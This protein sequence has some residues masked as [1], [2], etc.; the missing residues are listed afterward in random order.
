MRVNETQR[1]MSLGIMIVSHGIAMRMAALLTVALG[2]EFMAEETDVR[3][4]HFM[5]GTYSIRVY[6]KRGTKMFSRFEVQNLCATAHGMQRAL[7]V[8][9]HPVTANVVFDEGPRPATPEERANPKIID[10]SRRR[11]IARVS[12]TNVQAVSQLVK[13]FAQM[14]K[15]MKQVAGGKMP[16]L[17]QLAG[18]R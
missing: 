6:R 15:L 1:N 13:Q 5:A 2:A 14:K 18:G 16:S 10:G 7:L 4:H 9:E 8:T 3:D 11:R 12:G 17:Q